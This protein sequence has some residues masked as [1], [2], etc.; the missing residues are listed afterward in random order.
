[1]TAPDLPPDGP[2]PES[3]RALA[4]ALLVYVTVLGAIALAAAQLRG[5]SL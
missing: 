2:D 5:A 4:L 3:G 1:M